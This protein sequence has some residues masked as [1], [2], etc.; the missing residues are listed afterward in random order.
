[1]FFIFILYFKIT[2]IFNLLNG[3]TIFANSRFYITFIYHLNLFRTK[4]HHIAQL[5]KEKHKFIVRKTY[6]T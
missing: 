5:T 3:F 6:Y 4:L 2:K 1:M